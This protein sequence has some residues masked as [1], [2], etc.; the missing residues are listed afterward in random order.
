LYFPL[1]HAQRLYDSALEPKELWLVPGFGHA[2]SA[3]SAALT[4]R[5][6]A[7]LQQAIPPLDTGNGRGT[8]G[9]GGAAAES[10]GVADTA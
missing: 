4:D 3:L 5:V 9:A 1:E 10:A 7:W 8:A 2:E 6:A